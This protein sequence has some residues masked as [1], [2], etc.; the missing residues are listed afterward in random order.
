M[1]L[2]RWIAVVFLLICLIY[3]YTAFFTMDGGLP[4]FMQRNPI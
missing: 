2:D 3:G 4:P 1:A